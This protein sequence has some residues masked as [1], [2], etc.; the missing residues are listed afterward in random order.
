MYIKNRY[1]H[2]VEG[3]SYGTIGERDLTIVTEK[4]KRLSKYWIHE[5]NVIPTMLDMVPHSSLWQ[6]NIFQLIGKGYFCELLFKIN[7]TKWKHIQIK[8]NTIVNETEIRNPWIFTLEKKWKV[9]KFPHLRYSKGHYTKK[10]KKAPTWY[11]V[12][13]TTQCWIYY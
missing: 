1:K 13:Y 4:N 12:G 9:I 2:W 8:M 6:P 3:N 11:N 7:I 10:K 5:N